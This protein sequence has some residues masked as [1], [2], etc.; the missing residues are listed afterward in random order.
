MYGPYYEELY[1]ESQEVHNVQLH[2]RKVS[3]ASVNITQS[4]V[5]KVEDTWPE[6]R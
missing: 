3:E 5:I 1:R 2:Q 6:G 4:G